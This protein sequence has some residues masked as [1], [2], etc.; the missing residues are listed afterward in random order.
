MRLSECL[1]QCFFFVISLKLILYVKERVL[2]EKYKKKTCTRALHF[3]QFYYRPR[4]S[5]EDPIYLVIIFKPHC[6]LLIL[7]VF[8]IY[9]SL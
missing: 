1:F 8:F 3:K 4:Q 9:V 7:T 2:M 5:N 6:R